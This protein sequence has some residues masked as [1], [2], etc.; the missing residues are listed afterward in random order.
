MMMFCFSEESYDE[1]I[2]LAHKLL[3][4]QEKAVSMNWEA[5][6]DHVIIQMN[7]QAPQSTAGKPCTQ[8]HFWS[9]KSAVP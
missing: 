6:C 1:I 3:P 9:S 8:D 2:N 5:A 4:N 7:S